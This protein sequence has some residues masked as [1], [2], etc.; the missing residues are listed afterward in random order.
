MTALP[1]TAPSPALSPTTEPSR[2]FKPKST[3]GRRK[4][5]LQ[6]SLVTANSPSIPARSHPAHQVIITATDDSNLTSSQT[7]NFTIDGGPVAI[8]TATAINEGGTSILNASGS[9]DA[10]GT[11]YSYLW[12]FPD[13][14]SSSKISVAR[15]FPQPGT[16]PVQLTVTDTAGVTNTTTVNVVVSSVAAVVNPVGTLSGLETQPIGFITSFTAAG[17]LETQTATVEW[18]DGTSSAGDVIESDGSGTIS[19]E[20][21]YATLGTYQATLLVSDGQ[22]TTTVPITV[23]VP[24][25]FR[26]P[27]VPLRR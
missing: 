4:T 24:R 23:D 22:A 20:H 12:Q 2:S 3:A 7:V 11:I 10:Q 6:A 25:T 5:S 18:G 27:L 17:I 14:T 26:P 9:T 13:G 16:F 19:A 15:T 8:G 21:T 1:P